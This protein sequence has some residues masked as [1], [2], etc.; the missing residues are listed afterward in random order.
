MKRRMIMGLIVMMT[1]LLK[2]IN[3]Q[4]MMKVILKLKK[5]HQKLNHHR[6]RHW[7]NNL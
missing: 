2:S 6:L 5:L 3:I 7:N 1:V 4:M